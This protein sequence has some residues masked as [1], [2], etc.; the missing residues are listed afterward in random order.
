ME[1]RSQKNPQNMNKPELAALFAELDLKGLFLVWGPR[2]GSQRS[3][4]IARALGI[5]IE[6][7]YLTTKQG[8]LY[9]PFKYL[10][11]GLATWVLLARRRPQVVIIQDPPIIGPL[12]V[13]LF[14]LLF[15]TKFIIDSHTEAI[16]DAEWQWSIPLHR[17]LSKRAI[18]TIVTNEPLKQKLDSWQVNTFVLPDPPMVLPAATALPLQSGPM[19]MVMICMGDLDEPVAEMVQVAQT[20]P[21]INF[22][23]TGNCEPNFPEVVKTAPANVHF[24][25]YIKEDFFPLLK[26]VDAVICLTT[27]SYTF[28]SGANE[29]LW[30]GKPLITSD[31]PILRSYFTQGTIHTGNSTEKL[32]EAVLQMSQDLPQFQTGILELQRQRRPEWH[33]KAQALI[34]LIGRSISAKPATAPA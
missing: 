22:Y 26:A 11:Q 4:Q 27:C 15:G 25:G 10:Y 33:Q 12:F 2:R 1:L 28:L 31:S 18:T 7:L 8:L 29:A 32:R 14:S 3:E 9:A 5:E 23:I 20:L 6:Y 30:M 19:N 17:F 24:T 34:Q 21:D 13:Y 16:E